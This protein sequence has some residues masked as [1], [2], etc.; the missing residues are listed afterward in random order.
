MATWKEMARENQSAAKRLLAAGCYRSAASR[1]YYALYACVTDVL[2][3][4]TSFGDREGPGHDDSPDMLY[5]YCTKLSENER[6]L[7]STVI[8]QMYQRRITADYRPSQTLGETQ[9][10]ESLIWVERIMRS[11]EVTYG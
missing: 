9:A 6:S 2:R 1:A 11:F 7:F 3:G 5:D 8:Y 10:R 4:R